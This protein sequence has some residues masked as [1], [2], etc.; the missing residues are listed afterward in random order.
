MNFKTSQSTWIDRANTVL[1][2]GGFGNFDPG[3]IIARGEGAHVWDE[4][5]TQ[6]IDYL[7]GSGPMILGH[8]N[9][10][11]LDAVHEQ[12]GKGM[13][14]FA[15]NAQALSWQKKFAAPCV[16]LNRCVTSLRVAR[17]ICMPCAW[18]API[19]AATRS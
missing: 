11:V 15:N 10:E 9:E 3:I 1:P 17:P 5:G 6:Y 14:F 4:D 7:I 13:T 8:G 2:A 16:A 19:Q 12:L 18:R